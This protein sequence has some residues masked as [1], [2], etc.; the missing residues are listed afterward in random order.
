MKK[1]YLYLDDY[2]NPEDTFA[3]THNQIY[4]LGWKVVRSY[5]E[6]VKY[7]KENGLPDVC[8][9]DHDLAIGHYSMQDHVDQDY[10]DIIEEKT[11]YHCAKWLI[12]YCIDNNKEL[13][14]TILVHSMNPAGANNIISLFNS[15]YKY[16]Q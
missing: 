12:E 1:Y 11:G 4:L 15:Y 16:H 9:L 10:Y 3:Y 7:I 13:P 5:E 2:R 8:S 14:A 6:F